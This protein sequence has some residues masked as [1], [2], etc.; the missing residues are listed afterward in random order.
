VKSCCC[1]HESALGGELT[2]D[3]LEITKMLSGVYDSFS[4]IVMMSG[5]E[6]C[7]SMDTPIH[8]LLEMLNGVVGDTWQIGELKCVFCWDE[9]AGVSLLDR[10]HDHG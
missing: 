9:E 4:D 8:D 3:M 5:C 6:C 1:D 2:L 10:R 7:L